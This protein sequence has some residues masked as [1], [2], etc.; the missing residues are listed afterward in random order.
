MKYPEPY[1]SLTRTLHQAVRYAVTVTAFVLAASTAFADPSYRLEPADEL[2]YQSLLKEFR[3]LVCQNQSLA[4]SDASLASDLRQEIL[5]MVQDD[6]PSDE[7]YAFMTER[8]GDFVLYNPPFKLSTALLWLIPF[9]VLAAAFY[10]L[11]SFIA[12]HRPDKKT[13]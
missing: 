11:F 13:S 8:Y 5:R 2:R 12:K 6:K 9:I 3:C 7:I 10:G 4:D 1:Q